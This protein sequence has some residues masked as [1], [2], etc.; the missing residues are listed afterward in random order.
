[1]PIL[2]PPLP[3]SSIKTRGFWVAGLLIA[4]LTLA[5]C[6][7]LK[8]FLEEKPGEDGDYVITGVTASPAE[9]EAAKSG[10]VSFSARVAAQDG[11]PP[12]DV[13]WSVTGA[14][15]ATFFEGS[16]LHVAED[17]PAAV[18]TVR[19][20]S[21]YDGTTADVAKVNVSD[22]VFPVK[23]GT[24]WKKAMAAISSADG[25]TPE[26]YRIFTLDIQDNIDVEGTASESFTGANKEVRLAGDKT[27][28]LTSAGGYIIYMSN[29]T[30]NRTVVIDGPA[31][32][33]IANNQSPV[34]VV[35]VNRLELRRGAV[36]GNSN[37]NVGGV[38]INGGT[39]K[40]SG[41]TVSG[42]TGGMAGGVFIYNGAFE[43]SGGTISG[44]TGGSTGGVFAADQKVYTFTK[45]GGIIYGDSDNT[46]RG[47]AN[48]SL[49]LGSD[50]NGHAVVALVVDGN[51]F[52]YHRNDTLAE[53]DDVDMLSISAE[54][55][56]SGAASSGR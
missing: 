49:G 19:A 45:T 26:R 36:S 20:V 24:D 16:T 18:L 14:S 37:N 2:P 46:P 10:T 43:M 29:A 4:A 1:M 38:F 11:K 54:L 23:S 48:T 3:K 35:E 32:Y 9:A 31:L 33:G 51:T 13:Q 30:L 52:V 50:Y 22:M 47:D 6:D 27:V 34:V 39:F 17:E 5:G 8:N 55:L 25:G 7:D 15:E 28:N 56:G 41:G 53:E 42:N 40:M 12:Q 21:A 44:N